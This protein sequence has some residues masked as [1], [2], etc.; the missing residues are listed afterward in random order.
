MRKKTKA[1]KRESRHAYYMAHRDL[2]ISKSKERWMTRDVERER[3]L[4]RAR[5]KRNPQRALAATKKWAAEHK[6]RELYRQR[7]WSKRHPERIQEIAARKR[8]VSKRAT[9]KWANRFFI[10]EVYSL[11]ALRS[12]ILGIRHHVDHIVPLTSDLV[13]GLHVENN[14]S[15]I[16]ASRNQAKG[17]RHWP[18]MPEETYG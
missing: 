1:E 17:N 6:E 11:S 16:Y 15:V 5:Y 3:A 9:P 18:N 14:L 10:E 7:A 4:Q 12:K 8:S 13:C 2:F